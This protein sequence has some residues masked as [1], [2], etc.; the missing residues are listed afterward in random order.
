MQHA[1]EHADMVCALGP[2]LPPPRILVVGELHS[3][4]IARR[5]IDQGP[6][7]V[8]RLVSAPDQARSAATST[9]CGRDGRSVEHP[10]TARAVHIPGATDSSDDTWHPCAPARTTIM[11][12]DSRIRERAS[13]MVGT[14]TPISISRLRRARIARLE[15]PVTICLRQ[16]RA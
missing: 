2:D 1:C 16:L 12:S 5:A 8:S 7:S 3:S 11:D 4:S 6:Q 9:R 15:H 14:T 10:G 13:R